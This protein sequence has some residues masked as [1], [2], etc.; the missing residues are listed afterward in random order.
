MKD[1][2]F[3]KEIIFIKK[4]KIYLLMPIVFFIL[5]RI[6]D[7]INISKILK[8]NNINMNLLSIFFDF[9]IVIALYIIIY[10]Q[11]EKICI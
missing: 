5:Y 1:K 7:Y 4:D 3:K 8:I 2:K 10:F 9:L 6:L 11:I